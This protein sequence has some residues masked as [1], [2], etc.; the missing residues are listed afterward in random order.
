[1]NKK[2]HL[3]ACL[4]C[5]NLSL[6]SRAALA[7]AL[8]ALFLQYC[9]GRCRFVHIATDIQPPLERLAVAYFKKENAKRNKNKCAQLFS[10]DYA[11]L[12]LLV[13]SAGW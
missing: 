13:A 7:Y 6:D 4:L 9:L 1:V 10:I 12:S 2:Q 11:L 3:P 5:L 8:F